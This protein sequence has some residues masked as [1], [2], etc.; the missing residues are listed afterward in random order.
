M[1]YVVKTSMSTSQHNAPPLVS[2]LL[3]IKDG[4]NTIKQCLH[5]IAAQTYPHWE[6]IVVDDGSTDTTPQIV[7]EW[8][9]VVSQ[10]IH[11]V[12]HAAPRGLTASLN[13]ASTQARGEYLARIDADDTWHPD[14]LATQ[15]AFLKDNPNIGVVGAWYENITGSHTRIVELPVDDVDIRKTIFQRNPFGHSCVLI[16]TNLF[17]EVEGYDEQWRYAQDRD[18][19]FRLLPHTAFANIPTVLVTRLTSPY[20]SQTKKYQQIVSSLKISHHYIQKYNAPLYSYAYL[21][22]PLLALLSPL[23]LRQVIR[24]YL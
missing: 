20:S 8:K 24:K 16:R 21:I 22:E 12:H 2:I 23:W 5:S 6:L 15:I 17:K 4:E 11:L 19:W 1:S 10:T 3:S 13:E 7:E 14:K 9:G 18:L